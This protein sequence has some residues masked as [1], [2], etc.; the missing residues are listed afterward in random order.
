MDSE[1][2]IT[3][4]SNFLREF[5][6]QKNI[7]DGQFAEMIGVANSTVNRIMNGKRNPGSKFISGVLTSFP[8]LTFE[9]VFF[10]TD[11]LPKGKYNQQVT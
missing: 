4:K 2:N 11:E 1:A 9:Q 7:S 3:V 5:L 8:G 10:C 6:A